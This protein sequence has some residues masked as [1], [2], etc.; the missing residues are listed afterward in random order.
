MKLREVVHR[1]LRFWLFETL[2]SDLKLSLTQDLGDAD[3]ELAQ[4]KAPSTRGAMNV[5]FSL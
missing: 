1:Q 3:N 4:E 5:A 2:F